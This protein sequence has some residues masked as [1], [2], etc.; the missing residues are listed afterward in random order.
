M[1]ERS[2]GDWRHP[3]SWVRVC[4]HSLL[5]LG[6]VGMHSLFIGTTASDATPSVRDAS[7]I[8]QTPVE[9]G[10]MSMSAAHH[11][12]A[13]GSA[14]SGAEHHG[15]SGTME[16]CC[17]VLM[18]CLAMITGI[19]ALILMWKRRIDRVL[20]QLPPP[21]SFRDLV[22]PRPLLNLTPLQRSCI[23]RC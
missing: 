23:L 4:L 11:D 13:S 1:S 12:N 2:I 3:A 18:L 15:G 9:H 14:T 7:S 19:G 22:R 17:G 20:W 6:I 10:T 21:F 8:A 5:I 16:D